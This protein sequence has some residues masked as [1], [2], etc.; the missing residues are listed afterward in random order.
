[1]ISNWVTVAHICL[2]EQQKHF[3]YVQ[4]VIQL[5][6]KAPRV[7][8]AIFEWMSYEMFGSREFRAQFVVVDETCMAVIIA[9]FH[10]GWWIHKSLR[11]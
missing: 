10:L 8:L 6:R 2:Q 4:P 5:E 1:M 11:G 7:L 3:F 9:Y